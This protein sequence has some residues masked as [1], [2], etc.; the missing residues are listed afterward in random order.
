MKTLASSLLIWAAITVA[1]FAMAR[2]APQSPQIEQRSS[3]LRSPWIARD[4]ISSP[5]A[6]E[7]RFGRDT[8]LYF[9]MESRPLNLPVAV[10]I[11]ALPR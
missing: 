8:L 10:T 4:P 5:P 1:G 3:S 7:Q 2:P 6:L 9:P 11:G